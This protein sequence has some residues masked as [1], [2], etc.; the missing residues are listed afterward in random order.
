MDERDPSGGLSAK[1]RIT[2]ARITP[3]TGS[4]R[5]IGSINFA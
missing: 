2:M 1:S 3:P 5:R 4:M